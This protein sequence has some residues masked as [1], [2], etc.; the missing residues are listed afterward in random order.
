MSEVVTDH[1]RLACLGELLWTS[2]LM[3]GGA[4]QCGTDATGVSFLIALYLYQ[5]TEVE[6]AGSGEA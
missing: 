2:R 1:S 5:N 6:G 4:F 3:M